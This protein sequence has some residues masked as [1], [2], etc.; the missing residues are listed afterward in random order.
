MWWYQMSAEQPR[1]QGCSSVVSGMMAQSLL[2]SSQPITRSPSAANQRQLLPRQSLG[3][4]SRDGQS[5]GTCAP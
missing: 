3:L 2:P 4:T 1:K 5:A